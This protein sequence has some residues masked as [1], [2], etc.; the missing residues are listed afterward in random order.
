MRPAAFVLPAG[1]I[2]LASCATQPDAQT[3]AGAAA[4][5]LDVNHDYHSY[6][7]TADF[8]TS[9]AGTPS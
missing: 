8:R 4:A 5:P 2:L 1:L 7:N 3:G 6:A 9:S